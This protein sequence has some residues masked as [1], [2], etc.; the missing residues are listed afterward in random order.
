MGARK[1][2]NEASLNHA[3]LVSGVVG[4]MCGSWVVFLVVLGVMLFG[5]FHS[6]D[7]RLKPKGK[8]RRR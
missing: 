3:L 6:E 2:L 8:G 4:F 7:I 5:A 1:K